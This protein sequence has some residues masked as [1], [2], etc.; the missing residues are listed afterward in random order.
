MREK[1]AARLDLLEPR[2]GIQARKCD[3][4]VQWKKRKVKNEQWNRKKSGMLESSVGD[5]IN[6]T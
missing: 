3:F 2:N 1:D 5:V 4:K 6:K